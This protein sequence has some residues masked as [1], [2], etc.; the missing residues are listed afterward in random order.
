MSA[1]LG[2]TTVVFPDGRVEQVPTI[3]LLRAIQAECA[4]P[5][6]ADDADTYSLFPDDEPA[7]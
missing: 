5:D 1:D 2:M 7:A 6:D 3:M 4:E